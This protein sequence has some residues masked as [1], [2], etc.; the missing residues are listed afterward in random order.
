MKKIKVVVSDFHLGNGRYLPDGTINTLEDFVHD[1]KLIEFIDYY[2]NMGQDTDVEIIINGDFFNMIQLM[3]EEIEGG[4]MTERAAIAKTKAIIEGHR[5]VFEAMN[6]FN[7]SINRRLTFVCGNH[8]PGLLWE[9]VKETIRSVVKG[10]VKFIDDAYRFDGVHIE[11]GHQ[12]E[13]IFRMNNRKYFLTRG[14]K[15][16]VLN[17]PWGVFFV[18]EYLYRI[19]R[20]RPYI[21]KVKPFGLYIRW[22]LMNDFWYGMYNLVRYFIFI[23]VSLFS[24]LSLKRAGARKAIGAIGDLAHSPITDDDA[25]EIIEREGCRTVIL[26]HTHIVVH[27]NYGQEREYLNP[28]CWN[29]VTTLDL[30]GL[31]HT[32]RFIYVLIEYKKGKPFAR[33]L[34]WHGQHRV[35]D[36]VRA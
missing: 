2:G 5:N 16:P 6:R 1:D 12:V 14:F 15:E 4:I 9:G 21:D 11:H 17:L 13:P 34:Q 33:L 7:R 18:K 32:T 23:F 35:Y 20:R 26:G 31:G 19:K 27:K 29:D 24:R 22:S 28:G 25:L 10:E 30:S 3:P 8:D 36:E